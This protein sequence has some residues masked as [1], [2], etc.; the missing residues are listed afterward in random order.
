YKCPACER[1]FVHLSKA[2]QHQ[3][4][5]STNRDFHC[6]LCMFSFKHKTNLQRHA[7]KMHQDQVDCLPS[8]TPSKQVQE[9][10]EQGNPCAECNRNFAS[11]N[12]L[13]RHRE[14]VH[15]Q[16]ERHMCDICG[17]L[18]NHKQHLL[19][20]IRKVHKIDYWKRC[21]QCGEKFTQG[22]QILIHNFKIVEGRGNP[23][24]ECDKNF[25][26][27][28]G[29]QR[30]RKSLHG[31]AEGHTCDECG[32]LLSH[33]RHLY[34]HL[35]EVHMKEYKN[36]CEQCGKSF[37][38]SHGLKR[39]IESMHGSS[40]VIILTRRSMRQLEMTVDY[41]RGVKFPED[42]KELSWT[43]RGDNFE[44]NLSP[45]VDE[46]D[47]FSL[48]VKPI[49][50]ESLEALHSSFVRMRN[51]QHDSPKT[52]AFCSIVR[53][54]SNS[55]VV[56]QHE[57]TPLRNGMSRDPTS[58]VEHACSS[59]TG[60]VDVAQD[61]ERVQD[62]AERTKMTNNSLKPTHLDRL[63]KCSICDKAFAY[64]SRALEH[65]KFHSTNRDIHCSMCMSSFKHKSA[66]NC[67][68]RKTHANQVDCLPSRTPSKQVRESEER[69]NPCPECDKNFASWRILRQHRKSVHGNGERY[70]C[71]ECGKLLCHKRHL[72]RHIKEV[73][74]RDCQE[75]CR[76]C[77]GTFSRSY[78]LKRHMKRVHG[79]DQGEN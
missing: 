62:A 19:R 59:K 20:H 78:L 27:W 10:E 17:R 33:K 58:A 16:V 51:H 18:F 23:C 2:L 60:S 3:K 41:P 26:S 39:H 71:E 35:R 24:P 68:V 74:T 13:Q 49:R 14:S 6:S 32:K 42:I 40:A 43:K 55:H 37:S 56:F 15:R 72:S 25:A 9:S 4:S 38:R 52:Q 7:R 76:Q 44:P 12:I 11:W 67:H 70:V 50:V 31:K 65:Q 75:R 22:E 29:L 53:A 64:L 5:H 61:D 45:K 34:Q 66:F 73:H 28:S 48:Y 63:Y 47:A 30:H 36:R 21:E 8:K 46:A 54:V 1:A 77:G 57:G 69:G 79:G